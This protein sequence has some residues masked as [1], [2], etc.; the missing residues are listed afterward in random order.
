[1]LTL[2]IFLAWCGVHEGMSIFAVIAGLL[3]LGYWFTAAT[4]LGVLVSGPRSE[5]HLARPSRQQHGRTLHLILLFDR[6]LA[7]SA[8]LEGPLTLHGRHSLGFVCISTHRDT[9]PALRRR[10]FDT[11]RAVEGSILPVLANPE[12]AQRYCSSS[13]C[14]V[15][16]SAR[17]SQSETCMKAVLGYSIAAGGPIVL[18]IILVRSCFRSPGPGSGCGFRV[19][20]RDLLPHDRPE[21]GPAGFGVAMTLIVKSIKSRSI[22][23]ARRNSRSTVITP[24]PGLPGR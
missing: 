4:G 12:A 22:T 14:A 15:M 20:Q 11:S 8:G 10:L 23:A 17:D 16:Q 3:G 5:E 13:H 7:V 19:D 6:Q 9:K 2:A 21:I 24:I 1:M 18:A